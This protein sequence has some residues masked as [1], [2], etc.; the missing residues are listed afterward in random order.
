MIKSTTIT[1]A[2]VFLVAH[3]ALAAPI[4]SAFGLKLGD[5]LDVESP[6]VQK[7]KGITNDVYRV[8]PPKPLEGFGDYVVFITPLNHKIFRIRAIA[9]YEDLDD[10]HR[11]FKIFRNVLSDKYEKNIDS[12]G[13]SE[14]IKVSVAENGNEQTFESNG[15][16][17]C[18]SLLKGRDFEPSSRPGDLFVFSPRI[19]IT[20]YSAKYDLFKIETEKIN[21]LRSR[22][23]GERYRR[24]RNARSVL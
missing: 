10:A 5:R 2:L 15:N 19:A 6:S 13:K 12:N 22:N 17:V 8:T 14:S 4:D 9:K 21:R 18:I 11:D 1:I 7:I 3:P 20:Y 24:K 23:D 16:N